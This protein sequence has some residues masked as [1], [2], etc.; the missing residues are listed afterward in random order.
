LG[1]GCTELREDI[2]EALRKVRG[3]EPAPA[4]P[5]P[6]PEAEIPAPAA[7]GLSFAGNCVGR[8]EGGYA[9]DVRVIV[10]HGQVSALEGRIDIPNRGNCTYRLAD[11]RQTKQA[12]FV[13]LM[14]RSG[15]ACAVRMWQQGDRITLAATDCAE[16]CTRGAFEFT[17]PVQFRTS[18]GCY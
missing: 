6:P 1:A 9:E 13:E 5:V 7:A 4:P 3:K 18:G 8:D 16:R 17:W 15:S 12:P 11:F 2:R 10:A 14:A